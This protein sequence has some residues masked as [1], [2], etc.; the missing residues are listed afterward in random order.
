L[1]G[2]PRT[3]FA[4]PIKRATLKALT[5]CTLEQQTRLRDV[6]NQPGIR[7]SMYTDHEIGLNEH[8]AWISR[9]KSDKK[10]IVFAVLNEQ[11]APV[12]V[13][14]VNDLDTLHRKADWAF[15][16]DEN[17]RGGLGA[18][19]EFTLIDFVFGELKLE[20]LNCEVIETNEAVVRLHK[21]FGFVEEGFRR[22]NIE[23]NGRRIGV[24]F[25]GL[26]KADWLA[27]RAAV[28]EKYRAIIG[29]FSIRIEE[30]ARA[31][32][33]PLTQIENARSRNN[34]NWMAL[35]RLSIEQ[36]PDIAK[37]IVSEILRLDTEISALTRKLVA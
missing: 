19:L 35:L 27:H 37:P 9:L 21:K 26:T 24:H 5:A 34:V 12:G 17:E 3:P 2:I 23:K 14:S 28:A 6:R 1:G 7:S 22:D 18:A 15:Y 33:S 29:K 4:T 30:E 31:E 8:L 32:D 36:H 11:Q 10:Q 20:K 13:V 16:L 25:L